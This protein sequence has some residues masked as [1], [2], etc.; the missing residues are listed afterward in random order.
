MRT[1][2]KTTEKT[3]FRTVHIKLCCVEL[4][5]Y[6]SM[7]LSCSQVVWRSHKK[8][9]SKNEY[10]KS[11]PIEQPSRFILGIQIL[12]RGDPLFLCCNGSFPAI[13]SY[14]RTITIP[15]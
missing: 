10:R 13:T 8:T 15:P 14:G 9:K 6:M 5:D 2:K 12:R 4:I 3:N 1:M 7:F 11:N